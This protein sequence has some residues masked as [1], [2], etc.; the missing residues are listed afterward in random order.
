[1]QLKENFLKNRQKYKSI[2]FVLSK[3]RKH[4]IQQNENEIGDN[5]MDRIEQLLDNQNLE[6]LNLNMEVKISEEKD[7]LKNFDENDELLKDIECSLMLKIKKLFQEEKKKNILN[8][9][10]DNKEIKDK[11]NI[12]NITEEL[13]IEKRDN[14]KINGN[15]IK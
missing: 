11:N 15:N 1:M 8:E 4:N 10:E 7:E 3:L 12:D 13:D 9:E 2:L 14:I 5:T 6:N